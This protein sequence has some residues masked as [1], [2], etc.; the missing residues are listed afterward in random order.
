MSDRPTTG[1]DYR[2][3]GGSSDPISDRRRQ[4]VHE[5]HLRGLTYKLRTVGGVSM[6]TLGD[7][8]EGSLE[9]AERQLGIR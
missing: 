2:P 5:A 6:V 4:V 7:G 8:P 9:D 1:S 3:F